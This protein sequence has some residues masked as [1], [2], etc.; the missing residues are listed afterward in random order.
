[1]RVDDYMHRN[2][3]KYL[4]HIIRNRLIPECELPPNISFKYKDCK[5]VA[6]GWELYLYSDSA[7]AFITQIGEFFAPDKC[8]V[9][10]GNNNG[11][12]IWSEDADEMLLE[13]LSRYLNENRSIQI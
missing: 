6:R 4:V 5:W 10:L 2:V 9:C 11:K 7:D 13:V 12:K 3:H 1:M 8:S